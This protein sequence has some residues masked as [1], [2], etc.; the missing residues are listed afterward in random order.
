MS[1]TDILWGNAEALRLLFGQ[2]V[3]EVE[4]PAGEPAP[5]LEIGP[6]EP[7][8][9]VGDKTDDAAFDHLQIFF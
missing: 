6:L 5:V 9:L 1:D 3:R 2:S 8:T 7:I 4:A